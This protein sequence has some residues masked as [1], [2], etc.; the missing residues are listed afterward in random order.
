MEHA[1]AVQVRPMLVAWASSAVITTR[2]LSAV[3]PVCRW[4][5]Q[6][7]NPV[8]GWA[9]SSSSVTRVGGSAP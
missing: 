4:A 9:S 2:G 8:Q 1:S 6:S 7:A 3:S 5:K